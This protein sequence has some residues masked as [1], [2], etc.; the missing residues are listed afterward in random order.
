VRGDDTV[1]IVVGDHGEEFFEHN[2]FGHGHDVFEEL[3][4][5]PLLIRWPDSSQWD[6]MAPRVSTPISLLDVMPTLAE[7]SGGAVPDGLH[8]RSLLPLM[9]APST[10]P[11]ATAVVSQAYTPTR[12]YTAYRIGS[13]KVRLRSGEGWL[14]WDTPFA[15]VFDLDSDAGEVFPMA[16]DGDPAMRAADEARD[17]LAANWNR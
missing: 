11:P 15:L 4:H 9:R 2:G 5:V 6:D 14:P 13:T 16:R 10:A 8:G 1:I 17:W 12:A 7:L 3:V